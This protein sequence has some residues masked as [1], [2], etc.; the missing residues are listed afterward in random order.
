MLSLNYCSTE[1]MWTFSPQDLTCLV[2][3]YWLGEKRWQRK[4]PEVTWGSRHEQEK[5]EAEAEQEKIQR[6]AT[7]STIVVKASLDD[8]SSNV[9]IKDKIVTSS[10]LTDNISSITLSSNEN[11]AEPIEYSS[12][13]DIEDVEIINTT[14]VD[15]MYTYG[16]PSVV[17][18][19]STSDQCM[20]EYSPKTS[21][22]SNARVCNFG[23][24]QRQVTNV[25]FASQINVKNG[26]HHPKID[27]LVIQ[28]VG[29]TND[30]Y[31][32]HPCNMDE[33]EIEGYQWWPEASLPVI[34]NNHE[35]L[36]HY[37]TRL[38][39][40]P[41]SVQGPSLEFI[42]VSRCVTHS[43]SLDEIKNCVDNYSTESHL[44]LEGVA[45][46]GWDPFAYMS[47][48]SALFGITDTDRVYVLKNDIFSLR[49]L[50]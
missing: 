9:D 2:A 41:Y 14:Y 18:G 48:E 45:A 10:R 6:D 34:H 26:Y 28:L 49:T 4:K 19:S 1:Q 35:L 36:N 40:V 3:D 21:L 23:A 44:K 50:F 8:F 7:E 11:T 13:S 39:H 47:I 5:Y 42:S 27:T 43:N 38:A 30:E 22:W 46:L 25:D 32:S 29:G 37:E 33:S 16:A 20:P 24:P 15:R 17:K 12:T 31:I